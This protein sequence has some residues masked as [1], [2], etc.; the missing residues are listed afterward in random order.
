MNEYRACGIYTMKFYLA[1]K[2][3]SN[4]YVHI[5][6]VKIKRPQKGIQKGCLS[7]KRKK[8]VKCLSLGNKRIFC[9]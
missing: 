8:I 9:N 7:K 1:V 2:M 5:I 3:S 4:F 6:K